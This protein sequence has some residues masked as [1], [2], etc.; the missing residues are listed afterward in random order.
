MVVDFEL[1]EIKVKRL[2][3]VILMGVFVQSAFAQFKLSGEFKP[4]AEIRNG[5][6][7]LI[8]KSQE[9]GFSVSNRVR[10]NAEYKVEIYE[11][12]LSLQDVFVWGENKQL[13]TADNNNSLAVFEGWGR[14]RLGKKGTAYLKLGRQ[15][16]SYDDQRIL[17]ATN[18]AQQGR[19]HDLALLQYQKGEF[20]LDFGL[21]FS[22]DHGNPSGFV[23]TGN[24]FSTLG[25]FTYKTMQYVYVKKSYNRLSGSLL[26][27]NNGFQNF[28]GGVVT[29][30]TDGVSYLQTFGAYLEYKSGDR[31]DA[32]VN[33]YVQ[34]GERQNKVRVKGAFLTSLEL[35][36]KVSDKLKLGV[37]SELVSGN[38]AAVGETNAFFPLYGTNH[39]FNG[40]MDYFYVG[41]HANSVGLLDV[42][43]SVKYKMTDKSSLFLK[44]LN[45][46]G[47]R[48]LPSGAKQ[49]GTEVDLVY[50]HKFD[51]FVL[52]TGYSHM[53]ARDGM[54][55]LKGLTENLASDTQ[56]WAWVMLVF[57]PTFIK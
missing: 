19:N 48:G 3:L 25:A 42:H 37:G 9:P 49:L 10:L 27:V 20:Q 44:V 5:F 41:N 30:P 15:I 13:G 54:Y 2:F 50:G 53:F 55:E 16:L 34:T 24:I 21:A 12:Y 7:N 28:Q 33:A 17:G 18:W 45:F 39:K 40:F 35:G 47:E 8:V 6:G 1:E 23:S 14:I 57:K 38:N 29:N 22:Q 46:S 52:K 31:L 43:A 11:L 36:Y 51:G 32:K 56:N 4:R 26:L